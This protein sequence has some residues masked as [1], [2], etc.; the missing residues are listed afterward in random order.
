MSG[1]CWERFHLCST[2]L[3]WYNNKISTID[4]CM[5]HELFYAYLWL[6]PNFIYRMKWSTFN[7]MVLLLT[8]YLPVGM[9]GFLSYFVFFFI[10]VSFFFSCSR[11]IQC[12]YY[13]IWHNIRHCLWFSSWVFEMSIEFFS[14]IYVFRFWEHQ[15]VFFFGATNEK[16]NCFVAFAK[17][18]FYII[19]LEC[20]FLRRSFPSFYS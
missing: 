2:L 1:W 7:K 5:L 16:K 13:F 17:S 19:Q 4:I 15:N 6:F 12:F 14:S 18:Q 8:F 3:A 9:H 20:L 10:F 11:F